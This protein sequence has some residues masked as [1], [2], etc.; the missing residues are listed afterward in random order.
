MLK[1]VGKV[2]GYVLKNLILIIN[3]CESFI[4]LLAGIANITSSDKDDKLVAKVKYYFEKVKG[5]LLKI[6]NFFC[7][8]RED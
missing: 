1:A 8:K 3:I 5:V 4:A 2:V 7:Q 6:A